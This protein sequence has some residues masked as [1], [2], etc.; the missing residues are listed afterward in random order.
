MSSYVIFVSGLFAGLGLGILINQALSHRS[1]QLV[2]DSFL[3]KNLQELTN[4]RVREMVLKQPDIQAD[5]RD[6]LPMKSASVLR[7]IDGK[8]ISIHE[9]M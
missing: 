8:E 3:A 4:K 2:L 6:S 9:V 1:L 7:T 5:I